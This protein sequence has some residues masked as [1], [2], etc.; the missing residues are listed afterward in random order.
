MFMREK[1]AG[2]HGNRNSNKTGP[3][4]GRFFGMNASFCMDGC[5]SALVMIR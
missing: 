4:A 2:P 3:K 1:Q 5:H